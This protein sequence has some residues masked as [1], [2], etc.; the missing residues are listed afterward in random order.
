MATDYVFYMSKNVI[1]RLFLYTIRYDIGFDVI[2]YDITPTCFFSTDWI[3]VDVVIRSEMLLC[4]IFQV[5]LSLCIKLLSVLLPIV[6]TV[7][8]ELIR[9]GWPED[10]W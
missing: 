8:E 10:V 2:S 6:V 5:V 7:D 4:F 3:V 9:W 1:L